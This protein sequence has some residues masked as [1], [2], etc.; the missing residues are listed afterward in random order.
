MYNQMPYFGQQT[1]SPYSLPQYYQQ[2]PTPQPQFVAPQLQ[3]PALKGRPVSSID[4]AKASQI[5]FDGSLY[6]FPDIANKRIYTKQ[7]GENGIA[8]MNSYSLQEEIST[9]P[10]EYV[11]KEEFDK[12]VAQLKSLLEE[13]DKKETPK[14]TMSF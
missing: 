12:V 14:A 9:L 1:Q 11:T 4:E 6:L 13:R 7:I 5:D 10:Q 2:A 8:I 3:Q